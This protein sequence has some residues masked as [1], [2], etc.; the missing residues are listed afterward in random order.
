M[1]KQGLDPRKT[2]DRYVFAEKMVREFMLDMTEHIRRYS[3]ECTI[4]Y[5]S[6]HISPFHRRAAKAF[7]HYELE[8]LSSSDWWPYP[9]FQTTARYAR[10]LGKDFVGMTGKFHST[11]GDFHSFKSKAALE[12][13]CF[14]SLI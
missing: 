1:E 14:Q 13:D 7:T 8:S 12:F 9:Y 3:K 6:G 11:W 2:R 5:N 10:T 4:Y